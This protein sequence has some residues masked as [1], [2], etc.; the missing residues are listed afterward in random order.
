LIIL[1]K[2]SGVNGSVT[3][4]DGLT[5][6]GRYSGVGNGSHLV[7]SRGEDPC[8]LTPKLILISEMGVKLIFYGGK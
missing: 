8:G 6:W 7:R 4:E 5:Q 2:I 3:L 1:G